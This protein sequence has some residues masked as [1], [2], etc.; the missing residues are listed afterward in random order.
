MACE[1]I[2]VLVKD[3]Q[4]TWTNSRC[5]YTRNPHLSTVGFDG[6]DG[7]NSIRTWS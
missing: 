3:C 7:E 2:E 5:V 6:D 1:H 4:K